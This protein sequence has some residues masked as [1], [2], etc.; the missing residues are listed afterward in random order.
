VGSGMKFQ[1][2]MNF[3]GYFI[4]FTALIIILIGDYMIFTR[5]NTLVGSLL[6]L[7]GILVAIFGIFGLVG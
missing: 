4:L 3:L 2:S 7:L 5:N 6:I 1:A